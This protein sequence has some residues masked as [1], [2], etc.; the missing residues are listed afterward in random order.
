MTNRILCL[1]AGLLTV[2][3]QAPAA[4]AQKELRDLTVDQLWQAACGTMAMSTVNRVYTVESKSPGLFKL[5]MFAKKVDDAIVANNKK[6][7]EEGPTFSISTPDSVRMKLPLLTFEE[8]KKNNPNFIKTCE[9]AVQ[10]QSMKCFKYYKE[11]DKAKGD[12]CAKIERDPKAFDL[13]TK[14]LTPKM[15]AP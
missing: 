15:A 7:E 10:P 12:A 13:L 1:L 9:N 6:F 5:P 3:L 4:L 8:I 11:A 14:A 2:S